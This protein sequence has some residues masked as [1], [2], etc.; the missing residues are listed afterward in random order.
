MGGGWPYL[1]CRWGDG[2][3]VSGVHTAVQRLKTHRQPRREQHLNTPPHR[4]KEKM[5][6]LSGMMF[7]LSS[8]RVMRRGAVDHS[9]SACFTPL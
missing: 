2:V 6:R 1:W 9:N 4:Q 8:T 5:R 7:V 3:D